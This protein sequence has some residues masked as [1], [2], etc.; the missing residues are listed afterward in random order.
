MTKREGQ[1]K[2]LLFFIANSTTI[3]EYPLGLTSKPTTGLLGGFM[4]V[5]CS[6][7]L[8]AYWLGV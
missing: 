4:G 7:R 8:V 5:S 3:T 1:T 2:A 6:L